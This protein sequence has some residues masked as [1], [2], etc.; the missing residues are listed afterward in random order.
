MFGNSTF[1]CRSIRFAVSISSA[2]D[3]IYIDYAHGKPYKECENIS[4]S[5]S[6][7]ELNKSISFF[8]INGGKAVIE[9]KD[10]CDLFKIK[11][12][13][14]RKTRVIFV[15]LFFTRSQVVV[16]CSKTNFELAFK[17][18]IIKD[19]NSAIN[20]KGS[21]N[22]SIQLFNSSFEGNRISI[23]CINLT[24][25]FVSTSFFANPVIIRSITA[26]QYKRFQTV[27]VYIFNCTFDGKRKQFTSGLLQIKPDASILNI[28]VCLST[29]SNHQLIS[30]NVDMNPT[31]SIFDNGFNRPKAASITLS[32]LLVENNNNKQPA[33]E[34]T[35]KREIP[36]EV[37]L[38]DSVF[39]NNT[40][41]L[42]LYLKYPAPNRSRTYYK[43]PITLLSNITFLQNFKLK[44]QEYG[45]INLLK[46]RFRLESCRFI[47]NTAGNNENSALVIIADLVEVTFLNCYYENSQTD[48]KAITVYSNPNSRVYFRGNNTFNLNA[49]KTEQAIFIHMPPF[50]LDS[51]RV[52][53]IGY[54]S[55]GIFCPRGYDLNGEIQCKGSSNTIECSYL[56]YSCQQCPRKTYSLNRGELRNNTI[57]KVQCLKCPRGGQCENGQITAKPD[58][59]GYKDKGKVSFLACP[60]GYCCDKESC[61]SYDG[62][63]GNRSGILCG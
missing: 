29:F 57:E 3:E 7:I 8:G 49:L 15:N 53:L 25:H 46:G 9:C 2:N 47:D 10:D 28:T 52:Y 14:L 6:S 18:C 35:L 61:A 22:C 34:L 56:Y 27:A 4:L 16:R 38:L 41:A 21:T 43:A 30:S 20:V 19:V 39:R 40:G 48:T 44:Q 63:N 23:K 31:F 36:Y 11:S 45:T 37:Q 13:R 62:C 12:S 1:P 58:F 51:F 50:V 54:R 42:K 17:H 26:N 55:L 24:A 33:I 59:W 60:P 5:S 32:K